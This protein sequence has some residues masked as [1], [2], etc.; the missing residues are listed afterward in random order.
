MRLPIT[1]LLALANAC[2]S[3]P[4]RPIV[5]DYSDP[6]SPVSQFRLAFDGSTGVTISWSS[7]QEIESPIVWYGEDVTNLIESSPGTS[8]TYET[9]VTYDNHVTVSGLNPFTKYYYKVSGQSSDF[10][11]VAQEFYFTAARPAGD[12]TEYSIAALAD[13]GIVTGNVFTKQIPDTFNSIL[14]ARSQYEFVWH[15]GDFGYADDWLWEELTFVYPA[16]INGAE[17]YTNIMNAY[18]DQFVNVTKNSIYMTGPGNHEA[19]CIEPDLDPITD[20]FGLNICPTGQ[21]NFTGYLNHF[22]MP[23][24]GQQPGYLQNMWYSWDYGMT[25]FVQLNT[26]TDLASGVV[27]PD[28]P[29]G[30]GHLDAGPFGTPNQQLDWLEADLA[31]VDRTR[32][33]WIIVSGHRPWY[34]ASSGSICSSCQQAFESIAL[35]HNVDVIWFGHVHYYERDSPVANNT[36][37]PNGLNNPEAPWYITNG[38]GGNFEGHASA[39]STWP[40][41]TVVVNNQDYGWSK[42]TFHNSSYLTQQYI[43]SET[44]QIL[45]EATLYKDHGL[46]W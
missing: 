39:D 19:D 4:V 35:K 28:E 46:S 9:A 17:A 14:G 2:S 6:T 29:G 12:H 27:A 18:Y 31:A 26:E 37:D 15:S 36:V 38:A 32:T 34:S 42:F 25:H 24:A 5:R 40:N 1:V 7:P 21:R 22:S 41:Y 10:D 20:T 23:T 44:G 30:S 3:L 11:P 43:S 33:P 45:D 13:L 16:N 8:T